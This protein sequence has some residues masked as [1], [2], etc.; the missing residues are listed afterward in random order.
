[1]VL[2]YACACEPSS[3][4]S[5]PRIDA[6]AAKEEKEEG[7]LSGGCTVSKSPMTIRGACCDE[8][9]SAVKE[10]KEAALGLAGS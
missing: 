5:S 1:M 9:G 4:S 10:E 8:A 6:E 3:S 7:G 2:E